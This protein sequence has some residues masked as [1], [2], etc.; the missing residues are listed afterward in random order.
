MPD[1]HLLEATGKAPPVPSRSSGTAGVIDLQSESSSADSSSGSGSDSS[2]DD[3]PPSCDV[4]AAAASV[5]SCDELK[6]LRL[7]KLLSKTD[8][9]VA[10]INKSMQTSALSGAAA[11]PQRRTTVSTH[12]HSGIAAPSTDRSLLRPSTL[13]RDYQLGGVQWLLSLH[14]SGLNGILADEMGLGE[15]YSLSLS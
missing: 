11:S 9:I 6:A 10:R 1:L 14:G 2:E 3:T 4:K 12:F 7:R 5:V 13:L 8:R 15:F